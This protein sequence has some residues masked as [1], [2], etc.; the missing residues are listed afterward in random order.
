MTRHNVRKGFNSVKTLFQKVKAEKLHVQDH[1]GELHF[2]RVRLVGRFIRERGWFLFS[3]LIAGCFC[4]AP[5]P[6]G[7]SPH[8]QYA[9]GLLM[10]TVICF[11]TESIPLV[12][13]AF[14]IGTYQVLLGIRTF[15][16]VPKTYMHD[17]IF[18]VL[19]ALMMSTVL[20]KYGIHHRL[21]IA[22][23]N[24]VGTRVHWVILG[25]VAVSALM[26]AF[27]SEH[28]AAGV[29][30]PIGVGF[31]TLGGGK[32]RVPIFGKLMMLAIAYGCMIGSIATPSG[33]TRNVIMIDY[34]RLFS[35]VN[36]GY[37]EWMLYAFPLTLL[38]I[39][40]TAFVLLRVFKPE[41][42]DLFTIQKAMEQKS[43]DQR[44]VSAKEKWVIIHFLLTLVCWILF[45]K[46]IGLGQIAI[47]SATLYLMMGV[48]KWE[49]YN[50]GVNWQVVWL[51]AG[52]IS[53]G[54]CISD[55]GAATWIADNFLV[56][57][58]GLGIHSGLPLLG[59][60]A[61]FSALLANTMAAGPAVAVIGPVILQ[62]GDLAL[63]NPVVVGVLTA[64]STS[65]AFLMVVGAPASMIVY[66]SG[67]LTP[68]DFLK[69]GS[70]M[71]LIAVAMS[72]ILLAG[73]Y[74]KLIGLY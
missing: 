28:A 23:L 51:Y 24:R 4:L 38:L 66:G 46:Q 69:A 56:V 44:P 54:E 9:I 47:M 68:T 20:V 65:F 72:V 73:F 45:S 64:L 50:K 71:T 19:G 6:S 58:S 29:M 61:L 26:A 33:G 52:A 35:D 37:G 40:I 32:K 70:A 53:L 18:F 14:L 55:T 59:S 5:T 39:P 42:N 13:T 15:H 48:V 43:K 67:L 36:I 41:I 16:E 8:G 62:I 3:L 10:I 12:A 21:A 60:M 7:L 49:D 31:V 11:V 17:S 27:I 34:L 25:M 1:L 74:W 57:T 22:I 30:L 2:E 63:L